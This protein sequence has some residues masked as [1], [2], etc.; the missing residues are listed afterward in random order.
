MRQF[1]Q[2]EKRTL[3]FCARKSESRYYNFNEVSQSN[4]F[5]LWLHLFA[6]IFCP[7]HE[8]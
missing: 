4:L 1:I 8:T 2:L 6:G 7:H 3:D 5:L